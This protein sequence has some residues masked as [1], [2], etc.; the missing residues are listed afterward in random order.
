MILMITGILLVVI[1]HMVWLILILVDEDT[2]DKAVIFIKKAKKAVYK[3]VKPV[4]EVFMKITNR[5][6]KIFKMAGR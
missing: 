5:F 1:G 4:C 3:C 6:G 2:S